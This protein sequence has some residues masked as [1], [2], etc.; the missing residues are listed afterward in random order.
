[1][2]LIFVLLGGIFRCNV[3]SSLWQAFDITNEWLTSQVTNILLGAII[4][5]FISLFVTDPI[6]KGIRRLEK[7][8]SQLSVSYLLFGMI[9]ALIG[10]LVAWLVGLPFTN[11]QI[12]AITQALPIALV[13][14][15]GTLVLCR[16]DA[17]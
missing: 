13:L 7:L 5:F 8:V 10:L 9:G 15:S 16:N 17:S 11:L 1:M 3:F 14:S 2:Q 4:L 6:L 12:P